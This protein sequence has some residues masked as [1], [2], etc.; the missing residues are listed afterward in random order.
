[1]EMQH[2]RDP[3]RTEQD[4]T[5]QDRTIRVLPRETV[6]EQPVGAAGDDPYPA[7]TRPEEFRAWFEREG[8]VVIRGAI[9]ARLCQRVIDAFRVDV[10][11][12]RVGFFE[13]HVSGKY[14]RHQY[15]RAG[16]MKYP[17]MNL[18]D[19]AAR[20]HA[21]IRRAGLTVLTHPAIQR[22]L[23]VL[24]GEPSRCVHTM[25]FDGNQTT[26][27]HRDGHYIDSGV[28]GQMI[29][30]WVAAEDIHPD[31]GR[32]F[33]LPRSHRIRVPG[34]HCDPNSAAYKSRMADFVRDGP[35][36]CVAPLLRQGDLLL[37]SSGVIH[38]SLPT[39]DER[40]SRRSLTAHYVPVSQPYQW[41]VRSRKSERSIR[42]NR[43]EVMLHANDT[44][45]L[46]RLHHHVRAEWP[47][48]Y[49]VARAL[50]RKSGF[51]G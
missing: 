29:G 17:I 39:I 33:V 2:R 44:T 26:W 46:A 40:W 6:L 41:N 11:G 14:E 4:R 19:L 35:L 13:R 9:P 50:W 12:D 48:V 1:M 21:G 27:A 22:A 38:G 8:Y 3:T 49:G 47:R 30:V 32:F 15:T 45:R 43:V 51:G 20:Q 36:D 16:Y 7:L 28:A 31:A 23:A 34:E 37:W 42:I 18:Q 5:E 25:Y 24:N 10:L